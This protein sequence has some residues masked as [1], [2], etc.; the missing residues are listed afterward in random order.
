MTK[1]E[2]EKC[3]RDDGHWIGCPSALEAYK[4]VGWT[5]EWADGVQPLK[6]QDACSFDGCSEPRRSADKRVKFC[7]FHSDPKN[8]K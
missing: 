4:P 3:G 2:C 6:A 1:N 5:A 7:E 8:R